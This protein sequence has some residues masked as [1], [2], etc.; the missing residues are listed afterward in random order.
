MA[1][2]TEGMIDPSIFESLQT[3]IDEDIEIREQIRNSLQKLE[4]QS[5][6]EMALSAGGF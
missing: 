4:K 6:V 1:Q 3:K 5:M 2:N